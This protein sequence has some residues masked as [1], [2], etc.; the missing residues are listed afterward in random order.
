MTKQVV[1]VNDTNIFIDLIKIDLLDAL[2]ELNIEV[3]TV[4]VILAE[5]SPS[6]GQQ[7]DVA[8]YEG[9]GLHVERYENVL[10]IITYQKGLS[11]GLSFQDCAVLY[12]AKEKGFV[13]L[14]GDAKLRRTARGEQVEVR[15]IFYLLDQMVEQD[16]RS[17][18]VCLERLNLLETINKRL[19]K[20]AIEERRR[21][22]SE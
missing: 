20:E 1:V 2:F 8:Q 18:A 7:K 11:P 9:H 22:W 5:L 15:G 6:N 10:P 17:R 19:P 16:V 4:D 3:W 13:L 14:T 12:C 21:R